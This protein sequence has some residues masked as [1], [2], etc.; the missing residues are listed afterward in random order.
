MHR[1]FKK[2]QRYFPD[3]LVVRESF[4]EITARHKR[5]NKNHKTKK[6]KNKLTLSV[7]QDVT[8]VIK[9]RSRSRVWVAIVRI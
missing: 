4:R 5:V 1:I 8:N 7:P 9:T 3:P 6:N 2:L